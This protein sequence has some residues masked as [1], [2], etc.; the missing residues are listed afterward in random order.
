M[1]AAFTPRVATLDDRY[2]RPDGT[3]YLTGI[4][5]L[6]RMLLDRARH[7]RGNGLATATFVSGYEGS[8]L[9]GY[10]L[11]LAR[12]PGLLAEHDI[13]HRPGLNEELA[14]TA[15][16][17][18]QL[19]GSVGDARYDGVTGIWYGKAPG[20][21][22][23]TDALR[24]ANMIGTSPTGGAVALVGDDPSAKSSTLPCSSE[25]ALAGLGMSA[26]YPA[27]PAEALVHGLHAV[28]LSRASG[29]WSAMKVVTAMAD[30]ASTALVSPDWQPP[31]LTDL[32]GG[33]RAYAHQPRAR[34]LGA[35]L[36]ELERSQVL[37]RLPIAVEYIRRCGLNVISG[38]RHAARIGL[39]AAGK[40]YLDVRQ[41]LTSLGLRDEDLE[42]HGI[43]L[44][45]LGVIYPL[46]PAVVVEF[47]AGLDEVVVIE[48]KRAFLEE[49]VKSVLYGQA[50][51]PAVY[52]KHSR[53]GS[54]LFP[55]SGELD[56]D[57]VADALA[58]HFG[59]AGIPTAKRPPRER[60][61]LPLAQRM[62][63]FC[64]GCPHN[65]STKVA[66][67][68][69]VGGGIGCHAMVAFMPPEQ[70]GEVIGLCQMGGEGGQ[71]M[72]IA[73]F[74]T[75]RHLVQ[76]LGD[77]TFAHSGSLAIRAA[78]ASGANITYKLLRNSAVAMTGGQ[79]AVGELPLD[80][81]IALLAAEGV[82][83][84]VVTTDD[85]DR[86]RRQL[87]AH[88][89]ARHGADIRHRDDL[90]DVQ[91]ELA[92]IEG[93]TV[94]VHDQECAA[95]KRR[96]R[97]RGKAAAPAQ[98]AF[99]NERV[100]EGCGDCGHVSNCLSVQPVATEFGRKT[101]IHQSSCN[102]D[103][104][105]LGGDCPSFLTVSAPDRAG[106]APHGAGRAA[107]GESRA[108]VAVPVAEP[109][110]PERLFGPD[111][112]TMRIT[113]VGGTGVVT[114]AQ[115]LGTAFAA[116]GYQVRSL[117][118]TGLAQKGGAVVSDLSVATGPAER[119]AKLGHG[120]C[121]LYLGCDSLVATDGTHLRAASPDRTVAVVSTTEVPTGQMVTDVSQRFPAASQVTAA[122]EATVRSARFLDASAAATDLFGDEQYANMILVGAAYQAGA[123]PVS[124]EAIEHAIRLNGVAVQ[125]NLNAFRAGRATALP[126]ASAAAPAVTPAPAASAASRGEGAGPGVT[127]LAEIV[128][129]RVRELTAFQD[130]SCADSYA[131]LI[132]RVR[133][134][135]AAVTGGDALAKTVA[136]YLYKL[137]A[138]K[139][140]YEVARLSLDP[141][142]D[143]AIRAQFGEGARY[144][145]RLHPPVLRALG[146]KHKISLGP[147][148]RPAFATLVAMRRLRGTAL[149][150][151]GRT[152][153]RRTERALIT[154]YREVVDDLL[155]GLT[156]GNHELALQV[157]ALPD[158]VRGYERIK[159]ANVRTYHERL[160]ELRAAF[161]A[162]TAPAP[163]R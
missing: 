86:L 66:P 145:Y 69:L 101:K 124:A 109:A 40:T 125:N 7:D 43:R 47:A 31:A 132:E 100:C 21:D 70:V 35:E 153:V 80:R 20:L 14:A 42:A 34:L 61:M 123:L 52:G 65:S 97:R 137:T 85:P 143:E 8:P 75:Q 103:F 62:P 49:A 5:A 72:G 156:E 133:A 33:L 54:P 55:A 13:V 108:G 118:Q 1:T 60:V 81:L 151:F 113:G 89:A 16:S 152:E 19:A 128:A 63:Y 36:A 127:A 121:A 92:A 56:G 87:G 6:V 68:T 64:S 27:D 84:T 130:R 15:V 139:D 160:A 24:H 144:S 57:S 32:P 67:G 107:A 3:I 18:S 135:E 157:A 93:V 162:S 98:R 88:A 91:R 134:R 106:R 41:A 140:E 76:N 71:W 90:L 138:Y 73:P 150:P 9:G 45:K 74:V 4:Q 102:L 110:E 161:A 116:D 83:K 104:S 53:D 17:G 37:T 146:L 96:K 111:G 50:N 94:L 59:P 2:Q 51:A 117:D 154:E 149:D 131:S 105:C 159:L 122:I 46:E 58:R 99:I 95:E 115:I 163:A 29:L 44:L 23:A 155:A 26:F 48:D 78:V 11:E 114:I 158:L 12:H 38:A 82:R 148:F 112:F 136:E 119:S 79:Q 142:L 25:L 39:V 141:A 10:D 147:W 28:E 120:E 22:R 129:L 77:G 126:A 30:A